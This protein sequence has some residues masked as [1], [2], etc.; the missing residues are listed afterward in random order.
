MGILKKTALIIAII[1]TMHSCYDNK[2]CPVF[3]EETRPAKGEF[4]VKITR[5]TQNPVYITIYQG[6]K[7][8]EGTN[9]IV[10]TDTLLDVDERTY[11]VPF[12]SYTAEAKYKVGN[13]TYIAIDYDKVKLKEETYDECGKTCYKVTNGSVN[14]E[15]LD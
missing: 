14:L 13:K 9:I 5:Q 2:G 8:P 7:N 3:C 15:L 11:L 4:T 6:K 1:V 10:I 12:D